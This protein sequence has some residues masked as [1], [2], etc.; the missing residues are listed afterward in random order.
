MAEWWKL[1]GVTALLSGIGADLGLR[2]A[3]EFQSAPGATQASIVPAVGAQ[4][5][6][7]GLE[8]LLP[9][10]KMDWTALGTMGLFLATAALTIA[11]FYLAKTA[12]AELADTRRDNQIAREEHR[13]ERTVDVCVRYETDVTLVGSV[14]KLYEDQSKGI[15][16]PKDFA[17]DI[18]MLLNY[19]DTIALGLRKRYM[20]SAAR[21]NSWNRYW[22]RIAVTTSTRQS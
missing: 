6:C 22:C 3:S 10:S 14:R 1:A 20:R 13:V 21:G 8:C 11:T 12:S 17:S 15:A 19:L 16:S 2:I 4:S 9:D 18:N 7:H 5:V